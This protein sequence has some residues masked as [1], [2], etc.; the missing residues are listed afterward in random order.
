MTVFHFYNPG[1]IG[2]NILNLKYF[3]S[4]S[5][6]LKER[7]CKIIY[8]YDTHYVYNKKEALMQYADPELVELKPLSEKPSDCPPLWMFYDIT[9]TSH[10]E[11]ERYFEKFYSN[12]Q[13]QLHIQDVHV[14]NTL[15]LEE[16]F[17]L[18]IYDALDPKFKDIDIL[19]LNNN[20]MS[21]QYGDSRPLNDLSLYLNSK[22]NVVTTVDIGIKSASSL[23]LKEI[24]AISTRA[25]YIIGP[26]SGTLIP[27][28]NSYT[29]KYVKKWFFVG[30]TFSWHTIDHLQCGVNVSPI[31]QFFDEL[32]GIYQLPKRS[33]PIP[34][35]LQ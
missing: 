25:K 13:C 34:R 27:C 10:H 22:F 28:L 5:E 23:S 21:G 20:A 30:Q 31:K 19:I 18:A 1:H 24:G 7:K 12:V 35:Y 14:S 16:P 29:K 4:V 8:Y 17:L 2:D 15:W 6:I 26:N 9:G 3:S 32:I 11:Y 33:I